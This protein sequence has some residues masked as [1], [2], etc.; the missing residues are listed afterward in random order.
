MPDQLAVGVFALEEG[1]AYPRDVCGDVRVSVP[2]EENQAEAI[3]Q[4]QINPFAKASRVASFD[5]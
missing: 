1:N 3:G 5:P 4:Q 2:I